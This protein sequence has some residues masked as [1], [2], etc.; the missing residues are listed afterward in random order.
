M[1]LP[2]ALTLAYSSLQCPRRSRSYF[3]LRRPSNERLTSFRLLSPFDTSPSC[4]LRRFALG[5]SLVLASPRCRLAIGYQ[6]LGASYCLV[7]FRSSSWF[8]PRRILSHLALA[9][10]SAN[11]HL[12]T[13]RLVVRR[14]LHCAPCSTQSIGS[15]NSH[16]VTVRPAVRTQ[17]SCS[18]VPP[19]LLASA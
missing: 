15:T 12:G 17:S 5:L 14:R 7:P 4:C 18:F 2:F 9:S 1:Q 13:V 6:R 8:F 11:S 16:S 3:L 10:G 19:G